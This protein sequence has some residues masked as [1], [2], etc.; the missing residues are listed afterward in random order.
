M[1][2]NLIRIETSIK[3]HSIQFTGFDG[4]TMVS[5][6]INVANEVIPRSYTKQKRVLSINGTNSISKFLI[7]AKISVP[8]M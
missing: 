7:A 3:Q 2:G 6:I 4:L 1:I 8:L 5:N